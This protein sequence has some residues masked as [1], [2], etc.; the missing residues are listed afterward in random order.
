MDEFTGEEVMQLLELA[1]AVVL[2]TTQDT[3]KNKSA[4]Y[5]NLVTARQ[6]YFKTRLDMLA[7]HGHQITIAQTGGCT[8]GWGGGDHKINPGCMYHYAAQLQPGNHRIPWNCPT[9]YDGCNCEENA[10]G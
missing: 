6:Q 2:W 4:G 3:L 7:A 8:C 9:Y 10:Q 5:A 1:D